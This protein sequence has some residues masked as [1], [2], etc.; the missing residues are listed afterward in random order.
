MTFDTLKVACRI[1]YNNVLNSKLCSRFADLCYRQQLVLDGQPVEVE[2]VDVSHRKE[3]SR[4][5]DLAKKSGQQCRL[6]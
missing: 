2:I 6:E 5:R 4:K 1:H 3:V